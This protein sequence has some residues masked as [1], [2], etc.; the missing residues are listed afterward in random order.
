MTPALK[1]KMTRVT[2]FMK[3]VISGNYSYLRQPSLHTN[4]TRLGHF[5]EYLREKKKSKVESKQLSH[6]NTKTKFDETMI[7]FICQLLLRLQKQEVNLRP[8]RL[9]RISRLP[10]RWCASSSISARPP[11]VFIVTAFIFGRTFWWNMLHDKKGALKL[12]LPS[13]RDVI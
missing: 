2:V 6:E 3:Q 10:V 11:S 12:F 7:F 4:Y 8:P 9:E 1:H 13:W 5:C